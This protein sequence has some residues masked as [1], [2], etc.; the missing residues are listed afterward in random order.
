[1]A[2]AIT[3]M[4]PMMQR[5]LNAPGTEQYPD[6]LGGDYLGY[7]ADGFW[8]AR[9]A[10]TLMDYTIVDGADLATPLTAGV[11]YITDQATKVDDLPTEY[12]FMV[13]LFAGTRL[14]RNKI[15]T[16]AVNYKASAGPVEYE[17]QASATTLRA[18]LASLER[19]LNEL[20]TMYSESFTPSA[21]VYMDG[22]LQRVQS[23]MYDYLALG[24]V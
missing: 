3:E 19:R 1:M 6:F 14:L 16:L 11:D 8:D 20:K 22:T 10:G 17:Q 5:E 13:V 12:Q 21:M 7:I 15:L 18:V 23:E 24:V 4:I 9:L 2:T